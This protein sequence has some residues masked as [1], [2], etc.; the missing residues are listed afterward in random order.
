MTSLLVLL[1]ACSS[2]APTP[3]E[4][5]AP[6][7]LPA[8]AAAPGPLPG[9]DA[10]GRFERSELPAGCG[11]AWERGP[12]EPV[13]GL[14]AYGPTTRATVTVRW[15]G[16]DV[17]LARKD[18]NVDDG[19]QVDRLAGTRADGEEV[20]ALLRTRPLPSTDPESTPEQGAL[21]IMDVD[22]T[23]TTTVTGVCGC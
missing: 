21:T 6:A 19:E 8:P 2:E 13:Q 10:L 14:V 9:G 23:V 1:M 3:V 4:A 20:D 11:C 15:R 5:P 17:V 22:A 7:A 16:A 12:Q 18:G